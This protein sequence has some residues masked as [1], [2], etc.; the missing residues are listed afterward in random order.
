LPYPLRD[1][2]GQGNVFQASVLKQN[3]TQ[4]QCMPIDLDRLQEIIAEKGKDFTGLRDVDTEAPTLIE[5]YLSLKKDDEEFPQM[6]T[7]N[8]QESNVDDMNKFVNRELE[9]M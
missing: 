5:Y 1:N 4:K 7:Y 6:V 9:K 3:G 2:R 8:E